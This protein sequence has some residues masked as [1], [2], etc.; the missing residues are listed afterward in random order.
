MEMK[1]VMEATELCLV[2]VVSVPSR[3]KFE[4]CTEL[5][6]GS[7]PCP[8]LGLEGAAPLQITQSPTRPP[9]APFL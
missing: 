6:A 3:S 9:W 4:V 1:A 2:H 5:G 8:V 7:A